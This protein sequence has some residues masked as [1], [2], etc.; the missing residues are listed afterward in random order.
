MASTTLCAP[1]L[2]EPTEQV[3]SCL[4]TFTLFPQLPAELRIQIWRYHYR[5]NARILVVNRRLGRIHV[6]NPRVRETIP[7]LDLKVVDPATKRTIPKGLQP[8]ANHEAHEIARRLVVD[9]VSM[10]WDLTRT[11]SSLR[12]WYSGFPNRHRTLPG[13]TRV[14]RKIKSAGMDLGPAPVF[15]ETDLIY[16]SY[17]STLPFICLQHVDWAEKIQRLALRTYPSDPDP[18]EDEREPL[19]ATMRKLKSLKLLILVADISAEGLGEMAARP[20]VRSLPRDEFGFVSVDLIH[21]TLLQ[22]SEEDRRLTYW[23]GP[24]YM[25]ER[26]LEVAVD[27]MEKELDPDLEVEVVLDLDGKSDGPFQQGYWR[28]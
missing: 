25:R 19:M 4:D 1:H 26:E 27:L 9:K 23:Y 5:G 3:G 16:L 14:R 22:G 18:D 8:P 13:V 28:E 15:W 12:L 20:C 21:D 17:N 6:E 10:T 11:P 24:T 7:P 2:K